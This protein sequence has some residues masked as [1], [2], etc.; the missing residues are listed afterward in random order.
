MEKSKRFEKKN[1]LEVKNCK[2]YFKTT[3]CLSIYKYNALEERRI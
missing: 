1:V 2:N 3:F